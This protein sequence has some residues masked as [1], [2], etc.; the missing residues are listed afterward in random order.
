[1]SKILPNLFETLSHIVVGERRSPLLIYQRYRSQPIR[2][3]RQADEQIVSIHLICADFGVQRGGIHQGS[4]LEGS[5]VIGSAHLQPGPLG[6]GVRFVD[7][8]NRKPLSNFY[9]PAHVP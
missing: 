6:V 8:A 9:C 4:Q 1:M 5:R 3:N 7:A 2:G